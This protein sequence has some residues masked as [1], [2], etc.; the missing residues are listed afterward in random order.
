MLLKDFTKGLMS[1]GEP[2]LDRFFNDLLDQISI[3]P[4]KL[5]EIDNKGMIEI[6][7]LKDLVE[8]QKIFKLNI[9]VIDA[10][11]LQLVNAKAKR[12]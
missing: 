6:D 7:Y 5:L 1:L 12:D 11:A 3:L 10:K 2:A 4:I 8:L 9:C